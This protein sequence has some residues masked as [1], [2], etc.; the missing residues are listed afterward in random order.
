MNPSISLEIPRMIDCEDRDWKTMLQKRLR[1]GTREEMFLP[2][3][4]AHDVDWCRELAHE[5]EMEF[6]LT[7][8]FKKR[9][10]G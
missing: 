8:Y 2:A 4:D 5:H 6:T 3:F 7:G 9:I 10:S 1:E